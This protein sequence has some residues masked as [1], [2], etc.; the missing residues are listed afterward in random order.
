MSSFLVSAIILPLSAKVCRQKHNRWKHPKDTQ[1][2]D[3]EWEP[4]DGERARGQTWIYMAPGFTQPLLAVNQSQVPSA[5]SLEQHTLLA[6][7]LWGHMIVPLRNIQEV[8]W[9][10]ALS[11]RS[12]LQLYG[13]L[14]GVPLLQVQ[15]LVSLNPSVPFRLPSPFPVV[16]HIYQLFWLIP[17]FSPIFSTCREPAL[18]L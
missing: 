6:L 8:T 11:L 14:F 3:G 17:C 10:Q 15:T 2:W 1:L 4:P 13:L 9:G 16:P 18:L 5:A 12:Q 7:P